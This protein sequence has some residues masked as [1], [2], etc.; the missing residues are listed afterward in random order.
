MLKC[1]QEHVAH[2]EDELHRELRHVA[3]AISLAIGAL[4]F[5]ET[6]ATAQAKEVEA[7]AQ[8]HRLLRV[9]APP[10]TDSRQM[11]LF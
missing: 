2:R 1:L 4:Q 5:A 9:Q 11:T 6:T 7:L 3:N 10:A 8:V